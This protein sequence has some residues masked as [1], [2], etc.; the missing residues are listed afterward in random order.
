MASVESDEP[1]EV[2]RL[3]ELT[4]TM[5]AGEFDVDEVRISD[6]T[7]STGWTRRR[8]VGTKAAAQAMEGY[9][10]ARRGGI[11]DVMSVK[12]EERHT[13]N[14]ADRPKCR[15]LDRIKLNA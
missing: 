8:D 13:T 12:R 6:W 4:R 15:L 1:F 2:M 5:R 14:E 3:S 9:C 7:A 10:V 11:R